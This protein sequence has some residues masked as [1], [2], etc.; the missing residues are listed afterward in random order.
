MTRTASATARHRGPRWWQWR[1]ADSETVTVAQLL[2]QH[3]R[4]QSF[5]SQTGCGA[6]VPHTTGFPGNQARRVLITPRSA[7]AATA[8]TSPAPRGAVT[9]SSP[10]SHPPGSIR[11]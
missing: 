9:G 1:Q 11:V 2:R 4:E 7:G 6:P 3:H 8:N 5:R 10:I